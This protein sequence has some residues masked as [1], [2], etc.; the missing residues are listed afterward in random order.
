MPAAK[1]S[2]WEALTAHNMQDERGKELLDE[3]HKQ[4]RDERHKEL[5]DERHKELRE[6]L[7][8]ILVQHLLQQHGGQKEGVRGGGHPFGQV[9]WAFHIAIYG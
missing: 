2:P 6:V 7:H 3:E 5:R 8:S 9:P 1:K 4:L